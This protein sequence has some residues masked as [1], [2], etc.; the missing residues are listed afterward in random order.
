MTPLKKPT[1]VRGSHGERI[2]R[3]YLEQRGMRFVTANWRCRRGEIDLI[4][5]DKDTRVM[6]EVRLR[7]STSYG[8][9]FE[10][11]GYQKQKKLILTAQHYQQSTNYWGN[12]RFDVVSIIA[13]IDK[14]PTIEHIPNAF[15]TN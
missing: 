12:I 13:D 15:T 4:M 14:Q 3:E 1:I 8:E 6:V 11:V 10:T 7:A 9:G 2:A 5:D